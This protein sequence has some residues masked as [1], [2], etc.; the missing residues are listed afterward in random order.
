MQQHFIHPRYPWVSYNFL[1]TWNW[2]RG[3]SQKLPCQPSVLR[4]DNCSTSHPPPRRMLWQQVDFASNRPGTT[5]TLVCHLSTGDYRS[6]PD[7]FLN[8][9][10]CFRPRRLF[11]SPSFGKCLIF[12]NFYLWNYL[13]PSIR[14]FYVRVTT[15]SYQ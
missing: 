2:Q 12:S 5:D 13:K 15:K 4:S 6:V 7:I 3:L 10:R 14:C 11:L 1:Y 8:S 9:L